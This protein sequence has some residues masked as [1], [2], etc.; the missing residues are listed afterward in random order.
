[1]TTEF[2][3]DVERTLLIDLN[4]EYMTWVS[5]EIDAWFQVDS[6]ALV[7]ASVRDYVASS[8]DKVGRFVVARQG[9]AVIG[10]GAFRVLRE[11]VGELKRMYVRPGCRGQGHGAALLRQL[12]QLAREDGCSTICLDSAPF[13][14]R[15]HHLYRSFGFT[16][17]AEYPETEVPLSLRPS[18]RFMEKVL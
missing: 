2:S 4:V 17:R 1:M 12:L 7:G 8:L 6:R 16:D 18:W 10:M 9:D 3:T 13:M 15:A 11:G 5:Q 14:T